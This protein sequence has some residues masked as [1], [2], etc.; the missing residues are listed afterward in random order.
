[1]LSDERQE[2]YRQRRA[3]RSHPLDVDVA[4][5]YTWLQP[6]TG[7]EADGREVDLPRCAKHLLCDEDG[8]F[9]ESFSASW[10]AK[11]LRAELG[12]EGQCSGYRN[13][14]RASQDALGVT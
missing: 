5:P 7:R 9:P 10:E 14:A 2:V 8:L 6:A 12:R 3:L 1:N 13:P 4:R 11:V